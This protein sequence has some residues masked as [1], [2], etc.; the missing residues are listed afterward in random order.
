MNENLFI[1]QNQYKIISLLFETDFCSVY[2]GYDVISLIP[3]I[4]KNYKKI[5][6]EV[7]SEIIFL[8]KL[9]S[10]LFPKIIIDLKE[11][12]DGQVYSIFTK[13]NGFLLKTHLEFFSSLT[14]LES[15]NIILFLFEALKILSK[16]SIQISSFDIKHIIYYSTK[17]NLLICDL[18]NC[19]FIEKDYDN[20]IQSQILLLKPI[21]FEILPWISDVHESKEGILHYFFDDLDNEILDFL[22]SLDDTK[23]ALNHSLLK[24]EICS[25]HEIIFRKNINL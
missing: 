22:K 2:D 6:E 9:D 25:I 21:I 4:I 3:C 13:I 17:P 1:F 10:N 7:K 15:I 14:N 24:K 16:N 19:V 12:E 23:L 20:L 18:M 8:K 5:T 11:D